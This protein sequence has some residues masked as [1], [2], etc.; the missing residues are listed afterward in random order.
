MARRI[1]AEGGGVTDPDQGYTAAGSLLPDPAVLP[2]GEAG[3]DGCVRLDAAADG[4]VMGSVGPYGL[5]GLFLSFSKFS[6]D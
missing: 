2:A 1:H 4:L 5:D 3:S 6:V